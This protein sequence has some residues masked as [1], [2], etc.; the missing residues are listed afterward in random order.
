MVILFLI[1][2][3]YSN[4]F[5]KAWCIKL[6]QKIITWTTGC[7]CHDHLWDSE[8]G[9]EWEQIARLCAMRGRRAAEL[10]DGALTRFAQELLDVLFVET[11]AIVAPPLAGG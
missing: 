11:L 1:L 10:V 6:K 9:A 8:M 4:L 3:F 7:V 2:S 5:P